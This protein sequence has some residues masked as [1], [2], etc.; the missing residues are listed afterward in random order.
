MAK[1]RSRR[2]PSTSRSTR[3]RA[4][5]AAEARAA[6]SDLGAEPPALIYIHGIGRQEPH[7][8]CKREWDVALFGR[9]VGARSAM[10]Y[11]ADVNHPE[12]AGE[13]SARTRSLGADLEDDD[14]ELDLEA[15]LDDADA[16]AEAR[17]WAADLARRVE[18]ESGPLGTRGVHAKVLPL[19][20]W[21]RKRLTAFLTKTLI[22]DTAAYF[23]DARRREAMRARLRERLTALDGREVVLV[24]HSQGTII[25][26]DVLS[27]LGTDVN[28]SHW[29]TLGSPLGLQE[30]QDHLTQPLRVPAGVQAWSNFAD[31][32]DPVA[33]DKGLARDFKPYDFVDDTTVVNRSTLRIR[34]FNPHSATG[35]LG[36]R[37][38][39][40]TILGAAG[41]G[42]ERLGRFVVARDVRDDMTDDVGRHPVLIEIHDPAA[43][44]KD[45]P[46]APD[47]D[48]QSLDARRTRLVERL[49]ELTAGA[50]DA[51][52]DPLKRYVAARLTAAEILDLAEDPEHHQVYAV[53][54]NSRKRALLHRSTEV[55]QAP[56]AQI[57]YRAVGR[58]ITWAVLD[59][60]IQSDHPH[61]AERIESLWDCT[62]TGSPKR[63]AK[64][65]DRDG[66]GT[67]VAG[68]LAGTGEAPGRGRV[69]GVAPEARL[70]VYKVLADDGSGEDAW[71]IKALD[72]VA[73]SNDRAAAPVVHGVNLSLGGPFDPEVYGCGHSPI[74]QELRRLWR[75]G[76]LVCVACGNEGLLTVQTTDGEVDLN[77]DLSIGDPANLEEA[78]A[79]GS[80]N[81]DRPHLYGVSY[82]S[83]RGPTADGRPKPDVVAPGERILSCGPRKKSPYV[84]QSGT[85]MACPHVSGLLAAFLS[86][87][88]EFIGRPDEVK[89]ILLANA[90]DLGRDRYHQGA[91]L[92]NLIKMLANT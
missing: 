59:T 78:I 17:A 9:D 82:F 55:I 25:A 58:G 44:S 86:V 65:R 85:S 13:G 46:G 22:K 10:A 37:A 41:E 33:L 69:T 1:K 8:R 4:R 21:M 79:V 42:D 63:V 61:F 73:E 23:F 11:W 71:I 27:E 60:G 14:G 12:L 40:R 76:V 19:P 92:P 77:T 5:A 80:V 7:A 72:H 49:A 24:A 75:Q 91:G 6:T 31:L 50:E 20:R 54:K 39:R 64:M 30:V 56:P 38:V 57:A 43:Y 88:R 83:S 67:H 74:C 35:Y 84:E 87:R 34:G 45:A 52:I 66:H 26:Y 48:V 68:I 36:V 16:P 90:T 89:R 70:R 18:G 53:W 3:T 51:R 15:L 29:I 28:V 81:A 32:L 62:E 47:A 2:P